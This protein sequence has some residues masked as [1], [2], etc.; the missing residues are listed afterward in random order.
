[1]GGPRPMRLARTKGSR[2]EVWSRKVTLPP[3]A[4]H[5]QLSYKFVVDGQWRHDP[6]RPTVLNPFGTF[7]N[8]IEAVPSEQIEELEGL[9]NVSDGCQ[10]HQRWLSMP[11]LVTTTESAKEMDQI[12][13]AP[14]AR[15]SEATALNVRGL[16][17]MI[18]KDKAPESTAPKTKSL[19]TEKPIATVPDG[20]KLE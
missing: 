12:A 13:L 19:D 8:T 1:M 4:R 3:T 16:D 18:R 2:P 20:K 6:D 15:R 5:G 9:N 7:N 11:S 14:D 17:V 10:C